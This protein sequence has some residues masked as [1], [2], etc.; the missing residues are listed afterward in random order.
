MYFN[1]VMHDVMLTVERPV[2]F[3]L[4]INYT[5]NCL[6]LGCLM[7][8]QVT[9]ST[10]SLETCLLM[11][12]ISGYIGLLLPLPASLFQMLDAFQAILAEYQ[13]NVGHIDH[14]TWRS[15]ESDV[16][17]SRSCGFIDG[18][19]IETYLDLPKPIQ[20]EL[21]NKL[22]VSIDK[23]VLHCRYELVRICLER[24]CRSI[25]DN[26]RRSSE[27]YRR[28]FTHTL[29]M[30]DMHYTVLFFVFMS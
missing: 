28:S 19:L 13:P 6:Y 14:S 22:L 9:E 24:Q 16:R 5:E 15:F 4:N 29:N 18:D 17:S 10:I 27:D 23:Y 7:N 12:A 25:T 21:M 8:S 1:M 20:T 30:S 11:G 2:L 3:M 26:S